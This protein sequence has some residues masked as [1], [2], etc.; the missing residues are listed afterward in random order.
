[1]AERATLQD[2][3]LQVVLPDEAP[4]QMLLTC[5]PIEDGYGR[6]R[7]CMVTFRD[8]TAL[9]RT[10]EQ[11][12]ATLRDLEASRHQ[13][14]EKNKELVH[15][16]TR[17]SLTGCLNRRAFFAEVEP[18]FE[19]FR[20]EGRQLACLMVDIDHFKQINDRYGHSTGDRVIQAVAATLAAGM[21]EGEPLCRYGGEEFCAILPGASLEDATRV[22]ERLRHA[23]ENSVSRRLP[24]IEGLQVTASFGVAVTVEAMN[25]LPDLIKF[26]D[27]GLYRAK[28]AGRNRTRRTVYMESAA[29][30]HAPASGGL[31]RNTISAG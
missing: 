11:L 31:Q 8:V 17:D 26:A 15:L 5:A 28:R 13:I 9:H 21:R 25:V 29:E 23:I 14:R 2:Q 20:N 4:L 10:N 16:A 19:R 6:L 18:L 22:A 1:M 27:E 30:P 24:D 7:G 12:R 3:P